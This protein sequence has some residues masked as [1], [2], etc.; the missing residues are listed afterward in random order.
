MK[1]Q[2]KIVALIS[3]LS[4]GALLQASAQV[5]PVDI[6]TGFPPASLGPYTMNPFDPGSITGTSQAGIVGGVG[7]GVPNEW[8]TWGQLYTG[9]VYFDL[10]TTI[11]LL[12]HG[13]VEAVDFYEEP[14]EF[15]TYSMTATDSSGVSVTQTINGESGS[16]GVGFY[17]TAVGGPYLTEIVVTTDP[18]AEGEAIGEFGINGGTLTGTTGT[19]PDSG[20]TLALMA[21]GL[22]GLGVYSR[23]AVKA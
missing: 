15:S 2:M 7:T 14:N 21:L 4:V 19:V 12:L 13:N 22:A 1:K 18:A 3:A 6:G 9:N 17:E 23:R 5:V 20:W 16:A 11:T 8:A 10:G